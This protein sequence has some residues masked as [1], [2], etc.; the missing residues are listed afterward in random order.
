[1]ACV[2]ATLAVRGRGRRRDSD[3]GRERRPGGGAFAAVG[4]F[5]RGEND[6]VEKVAG[7]QR[8]EG[9]ALPWRGV[10]NLADWG[11]GPR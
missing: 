9:V 7:E 8:K 11:S 10:A 3:G 2:R 6:P 4:A 1:M 5:R